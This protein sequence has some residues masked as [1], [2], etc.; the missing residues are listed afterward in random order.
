ML[1]IRRLSFLDP[2]L[3]GEAAGRLTS[4]KRT[5]LQCPRFRQAS[6]PGVGSAKQSPA[7]SLQ[8]RAGLVRRPRKNRGSR[9]RQS[10]SYAQNFL[11]PEAGRAPPAIAVVIV[12]CVGVLVVEIFVRPAKLAMIPLVLP[13]A[14]EALLVSFIVL[15]LELMMRIVMFGVVAGVASVL[16]A[17]VVTREG[18]CDVRLTCHPLPHMFMVT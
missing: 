8:A 10:K 17:V 4:W 5:K 13:A 3:R 1:C 18:R 15:I 14:A 6:G 7:G 12:S 11:V 9:K 16:V 2:R